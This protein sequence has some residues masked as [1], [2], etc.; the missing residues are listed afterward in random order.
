MKR[1]SLAILGLVSAMVPA[2]AQYYDYP[3]QRRNSYDPAPRYSYEPPPRQ[4]YRQDRYGWDDQPRYRPQV[5]GNVCYT[6]RGSC[7]TRPA[8]EQ[9]SCACNIP[10]FGLKRGGVIAGGQW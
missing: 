6:S 9:S 7:Q 3:P 1:F 5:I 10:G 8:P 4:Y 2:A